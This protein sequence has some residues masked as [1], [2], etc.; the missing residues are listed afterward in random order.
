VVWDTQDKHSKPWKLRLLGD[1]QNLGQIIKIR[2]GLPDVYKIYTADELDWTKLT[3]LYLKSI[4][5]QRGNWDPYGK[6]A[7]KHDILEPGWRGRS[8]LDDR[9]AFQLVS[10]I[11]PVL[12]HSPKWLHFLFGGD[13]V[14]EPEHIYNKEGQRTNT[15]MRVLTIVNDQLKNPLVKKD[16]IQ[17]VPVDKQAIF[18]VEAI[19]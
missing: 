9:T 5:E 11:R 2:H 13:Q 12:P 1:G 4:P 17:R 19:E 10:D 7:K 14:Y 15:L 3:M 18:R 6:W 8:S 16:T